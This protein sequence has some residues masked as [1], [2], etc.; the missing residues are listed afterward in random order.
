MPALPPGRSIPSSAGTTAFP[1]VE[2]SGLVW[3]CLDADPLLPCP[4]LPL[5]GAVDEVATIVG[6]PYVW[7]CHASRR[8]ENFLD[9]AHFAFVHDGTLG[10]SSAPQV[11]PYDVWRDETGLRATQTRTEPPNTGVKATE[12]DGSSSITTFVDYLCPTPLC[13]RLDQHLSGGR[14]FALTVISSPTAADVCTNFWMLERNYDVDGPDAPYLDFQK[15]VN[16]E[17]RVVIESLVPDFV[18]SDRRDEVHVAT[19]DRMAVHYRRW[20]DELVRSSTPTRL[21]RSRR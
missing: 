4:D 9:F 8:M 14:R 7:S 18:S 10:S 21:S 16:E 1:A 13:G 17:D 15:R 6:D 5:L 2:R 12:G 19:V 20:L 3:T 11:P